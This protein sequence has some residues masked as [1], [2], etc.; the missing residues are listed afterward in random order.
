MS[1]R[2]FTVTTKGDDVKTWQN[3]VKKLFKE[4]NID[5]P[6]VADGIYGAHTRAYTAALVHAN[7][8]SATRQMANGVGPKL[9]TKLRH[10]PESLTPAQRKT[11]NASPS[12]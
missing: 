9:R 4:M 7:G 12:R 5:C 3:Q 10:A 2:T 8:L 1:D 6:I 11:R